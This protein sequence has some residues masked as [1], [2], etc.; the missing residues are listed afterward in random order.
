MLLIRAVI[1]ADLS[2]PA[3]VARVREELR[4]SGCCMPPAFVRPDLHMVR[5]GLEPE[6][7]GRQAHQHH[8]HDQR[9]LAAE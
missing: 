9:G 1:V 8:R 7:G 6:R 4:N 3:L 2:D 5:L